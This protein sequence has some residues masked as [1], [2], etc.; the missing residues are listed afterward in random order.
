MDDIQRLLRDLA[1]RDAPMH[2][3]EASALVSDDAWAKVRDDGLVRFILQYC[4]LS[5]AGR[6]AAGADGHL[7]AG[8]RLS[9]GKTLPPRRT[10]E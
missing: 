1:A 6:I 4:V 7:Y 3:T 8:F 10:R 9:K 5:E 2:W